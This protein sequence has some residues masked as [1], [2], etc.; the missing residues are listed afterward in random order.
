MVSS[1]Q[2]GQGLGYL[3]G[4]PAGLQLPGRQVAV[5]GKQRQARG[6]SLR[7]PGAGLGLMEPGPGDTPFHHGVPEHLVG[8]GD[9]GPGGPEV[10]GQLKGRQGQGGSPAARQSLPGRQEQVRLG[11]A[12]AIDGLL[13]VPHHHQGAPVPPASRPPDGRATASG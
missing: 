5:P 4:Q 3:P 11:L 12:P 8:P 1:P 2:S 9:Q 10:G 13:G 7:R 6:G